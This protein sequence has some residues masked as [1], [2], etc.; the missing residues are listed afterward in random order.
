MEFEARQ[1]WLP[2]VPILPSLRPHLSFSYTLYYPSI[3]WTLY[4]ASIWPP[5]RLLASVNKYTSSNPTWPKSRVSVGI[6]VEMKNFHTAA[7]S[8]LFKSPTH[9]SENKNF[10]EYV[11]VD[12]SKSKQSGQNSGLLKV[13]VHSKKTW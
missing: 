9:V 7:S 8:V 4:I 1:E 10:G 13:E 12:W 6:T 11:D 5:G 2:L 3:L